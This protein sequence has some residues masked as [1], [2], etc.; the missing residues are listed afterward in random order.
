VVL[1]NGREVIS[2]SRDPFA[3]NRHPRTLVGWNPAGDLMLVTV[4]GRQSHSSGVS[5]VEAAD[6]LRKVGATSGFNLDGGGSTT[7]VSLAP[8]ATTPR[9]LN[10][11][12]DGN[13]RRVTTVIAVVPT[14]AAAVRS[15]VT[16]PPPPQPP[17]APPGPPPPDEA[18]TE[19]LA[20]ATGPPKEPTTTTTTA[21]PTTLP[22]TTTTLPPPP[23]P[24]VTEPAEVID[25]VAAPLPPPLDLPDDPST[26]VPGTVAALALAGAAGATA[27]TARRTRRQT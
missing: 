27:R 14:N 1:T 20:A 9:V 21:A 16:A 17:A 19:G 12:S 25:E 15:V 5:L 3:T 23:P 18:S 6:V 10:R 13:E 4:D 11:P 26:L 7:F 8:G 24:P 2:H 22:P